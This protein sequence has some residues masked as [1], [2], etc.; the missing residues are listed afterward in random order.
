MSVCV[1]G[2]G[3][4]VVQSGALVLTSTGLMALWGDPLPDATLG[5]PYYYTL[6]ASG[7][8]P[9]YTFFI[10]AGTLPA[11][12]SLNTSTGVISGT[13]TTTVS[14]DGVSFS[15]TDSP[16][17]Q[18]PAPTGIFAYPSGS[19]NFWIHGGSGPNN[20]PNN[21]MGL[22]AEQANPAGAGDFVVN[23]W[24]AGA[25]TGFTPGS[26]STAQLGYVSSG[27]TTSAQ[28]QGN[29]VGVYLQSID[30]P[31]DP[32]N[33][34]M[35]IT[36]QINYAG[37]SIYTSLSTTL[38]HYMLMQ[39]PTATN[40]AG[41]GTKDV[42]VTVDSR[43]QGPGGVFVATS[44]KIYS[45]AGSG[46]P[47]VTVS[48][49]IPTSTYLMNIPLDP[50]NAAGYMTVLAGEFTH[51]TWSGLLPISFSVT[52][53]QFQTGLQLLQTNYPSAFPNSTYVDPT[54]YTLLNSHINAEFHFTPSTDDCTLGWSASDWFAV[55]F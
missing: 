1:D 3:R 24:N 12:L 41:T 45:M 44:V 30:R 14:M 55:V 52:G 22:I 31:S 10:S 23:G 46:I 33:S 53:A 27:Q 42:Y 36:P 19:Q 17:F 34:K 39:V 4:L 29:E 47:L 32:G 21:V 40:T 38:L 48:Q 15:V 16:L 49:D 5:A 35:M 13:P 8:N 7:G 54:Q 28:W 9:P 26:P 51:N 43:Y 6:A 37:Q 20:P 18:L 25:L 2:S 11:G 50:T